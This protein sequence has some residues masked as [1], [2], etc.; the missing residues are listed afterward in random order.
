MK[1]SKSDYISFLV[2]MW[3]DPEGESGWMVQIEHIPSGEKQHFIS[4]AAFSN[5]L[6]EYVNDQEVNHSN[7]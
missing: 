3:R 1:A 5:Y 4:L 2:R 6:L 7:P